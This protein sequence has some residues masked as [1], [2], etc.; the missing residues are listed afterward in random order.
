MNDTLYDLYPI[1][2]Y[3]PQVARVQTHGRHSDTACRY[4]P[5]R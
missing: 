5:Q 2:A 4:K 1:R 3:A